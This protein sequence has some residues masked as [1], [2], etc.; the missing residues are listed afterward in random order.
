MRSQDLSIWVCDTSLCLG[1]DLRE[2]RWLV[3]KDS[4]YL[5]FFVGSRSSWRFDS[6]GMVGAVR[7]MTGRWD[8]FHI[9]WAGWVP[10]RARSRDSIAYLSIYWGRNLYSLWHR[11]QVRLLQSVD[12][13]RWHPIT[14]PPQLSLPHA[15]ETD[16][17]IEPDGRLWAITRSEGRGSYLSYA[18][19]PESVWKATPL[20][21]KYDSPLL[22]KVPDGLYLIAR[23]HVLGEADRAPW[24]FPAILRRYYNLALYSLS[25]KRT[26]L[27][28]IDTLEREVVWIK[29]LPGWGDT[30]FPAIYPDSGQE[31]VLINYTSPL[32]G[33]DVWWIRGQLGRTILY[34]LRLRWQG[35]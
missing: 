15:T 5:Y 12:G 31:F 7:A 29:D 30:A 24:F 27:Y 18:V 2:P 33:K 23:R 13:R 3:W 11:A 26:A 32:S 4:L 6:E 16:F 34:K 28:R 35:R 9:G 8:T 1:R 22:F 17:W 20:E 21:Y 14:T 25:R 10:W 19:H